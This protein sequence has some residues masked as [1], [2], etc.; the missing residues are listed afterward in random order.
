[1]DARAVTKA[2]G[3][4]W[5]GSFG[6]C[7]CPVHADRTPS[8]KV[9][10]DERKSDGIDVHCFAGC[11]WR[12]VKAE[13]N[14]QG[15]LLEFT[16]NKLETLTAPKVLIQRPV[17]GPDEDAEAAKKLKRAET[18]WRTAVSLQGT[19][20]SRYF[21][22]HRG[23]DIA[24][25][26]LSHALRFHSDLCA[27]VA[28]MTDPLTNQSCGVHRTFL[29]KEGAKRDRMMLGKQ[30]VVRVSPDEAVTYGLG[31][32]EGVED[33][34]AILISGWKPVWAATSAG[35]IARFPVLS[36]IEA[37]TIF[38]D[39]DEAGRKAAKACATRWT[40]AGRE[41]FMGIQHGNNDPKGHE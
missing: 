40:A 24:A 38:P 36:G 37:L 15:L 29:N 16:P 26:D 2:L 20:G 27:V 32:A 34:L 18:I 9:S 6:L 33:A 25:L 23:L 4:K 28:L 13:L 30:G 41:V 12:H 8:L 19:L 22:E 39:N 11:D 21:I 31:I 5:Q 7:R 35:S 3:G 1:M 10:N 17:S 14:R